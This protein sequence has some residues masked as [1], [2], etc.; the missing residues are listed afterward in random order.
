MVDKQE[1]W[2][3]GGAN[4]PND[5]FTRNHIVP[6]KVSHINKF[7]LSYNNT[8]VFITA[9]KYD[10]PEQKNANLYGD[11][12]LDFDGDKKRIEE[13]GNER[14][15]QEV[16]SDVIMA[17]AYLETIF[18]IPKDRVEIY[19]SGSKGI[20]IIVPADILGVTPHKQLNMI[21]RI[22]AEDISKMLK[23]NTLDLK[24]YDNRR[25]FRLPNSK[26]AK[27][28]LYKV[29]ISVEELRN[30][31]LSDIVEL[32][33]SPRI[34]PEKPKN[35]VM[36]AGLMYRTYLDRV[37]TKIN[38]KHIT[39]V[40]YSKTLDITPPC[41]EELLS[42]KVPEGQRNNTAAALTSFFKQHGFEQEEAKAKLE[43]W[44]NTNCDPPMSDRDIETITQSIYQ[45]EYRYG[46]NGL[47]ILA[48]CDRLRCPLRRK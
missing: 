41:I 10:S 20:H 4:L 28:G 7:R 29:P 16:K 15:Y 30:L 22:I 34:L 35:I 5:K 12:Y 6:D 47:S 21:F 13:I 32:A 48:S 42:S 44:N 19:F 11:L 25:L 37:E 31:V 45:G 40:N 33:T 18:G 27:T 39:P 24:I 3:E 46:C 2:I 1:W 8:G 17:L 38:K 14:T 26:H 9:Y 36:K 23:Y 43:E